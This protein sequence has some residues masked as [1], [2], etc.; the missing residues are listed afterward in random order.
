MAS[1]TRHPFGSEAASG[2]TRVAPDVVQDFAFA[3]TV[4]AADL[5][6]VV[7]PSGIVVSEDHHVTALDYPLDHTSYEPPPSARGHHAYVEAPALEPKYDGYAGYDGYYAQ[8]PAQVTAPASWWDRVRFGMQRSREEMTLLWSAT[9]SLEQ[10]HDGQ[11]AVIHENDPFLRAAT[12]GR[13]VRTLWS[14]FEWD[15]TDLVRAAWIGLLVFVLAAT[16]GAFV[17]GSSSTSTSTSTPG[18]S[19][20]ASDHGIDVG[21]AHTYTQR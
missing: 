5:D 7:P 10:T 16:V 18:S 9:A 21:A 2:S 13:R 6:E 4:V 1:S 19:V 8:A 14:F 12:V 15:R 20:M 11:G 3:D 17:L